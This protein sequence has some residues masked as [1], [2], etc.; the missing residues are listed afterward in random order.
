LRASLALLMMAAIIFAA[1]QPDKPLG[2]EVDEG[3]ALSY[4]NLNKV[5]VEKLATEMVLLKPQ[6]GYQKVLYEAAS[7]YLEEAR[8]LY[9]AGHLLYLN[10]VYD[11]ALAHYVSSLYYVQL[12][13]HLLKFYHFESLNDYVDYSRALGNF[14]VAAAFS[15]YKASC[16][17]ATCIN[18]TRVVYVHSYKTMLNLSNTINNTINNLPGDF[19]EELARR[20]VTMANLASRLTT[21]AYA[22]YVLTLLPQPSDSPLTGKAQCILKGIGKAEWLPSACYHLYNPLEPSPCSS[23]YGL[24]ASYVGL[25]DLASVLCGG[26]VG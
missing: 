17:T 18:S 21:M 14:G 11:T 8:R 3:L 7:K 9:R 23:F 22:H 6:S 16:T 10:G 20:A 5:Y 2:I 1:C 25:N 19:N 13:Q 4:D 24:I 26:N 12:V 15:L